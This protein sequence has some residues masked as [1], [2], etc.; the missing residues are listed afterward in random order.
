[1]LKS[2]IQERLKKKEILL[3][4][5]IVIGYPT[6]DDSFKI[7]ESMVE[8]GVDLMELQIPFTEPIADGPVILQANQESLSGG[9][10]VAKCF[11]FAYEASSRFE[12][13]FLFM[14]YYNIIFKF[15]VKKFIESSV[16]NGIRGIIV[17]DLPP[18]EGEEYLTC[19]RENKL[20]PI[21]I[22]SPATDDQRMKYLASY[23]EGFIYCVARKGVTGAGTDFSDDLAR[24]VNLIAVSPEKLR[25]LAN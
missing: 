1:M 23:G 22:F 9:A 12:I 4:T 13:P 8:S 15:G 3:M 16:K 2:Y 18:E 7:V 5:H 24:G 14:T 20:S 25:E 11:D 6:F 19:I 10:T 21:F 17:P